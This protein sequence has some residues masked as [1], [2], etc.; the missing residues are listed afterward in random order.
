VESRKNPGLKANVISMYQS[1]FQREGFFRPKI[2]ANYKTYGKLKYQHTVDIYFEFI[3]M[4]NLERTVI[5]TVEDTEVTEGD[6]LEF[7]YVLKDLRFLAKGIIYYD[8][9]ASIEAKEVADKVNIDLK[10][11][12]FLSEVQKSAL[13][14]LKT[15][16]PEGD[17]IGDPF[18]VAMETVKNNYDENTGNYNMINNAILL[19]LS[20]KQADNYCKKLNGRYK[21]FGISQNH[22]KILFALQEKNMFPDFCIAFPEFEQSNDTSIGC[23]SITPEKFKK[24]YLRGDNNE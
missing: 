18:W 4:N 24:I 2:V 11:F 22:L 13:S 23:Y 12:N 7:A 21:V 3:Q 19:F 10:K 1:Y 8:D 6:V 9:T 5:K 20:K 15:M 17:I 16:L 14:V